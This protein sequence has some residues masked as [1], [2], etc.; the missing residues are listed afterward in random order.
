M[1]SSHEEFG[2]APSEPVEPVQPR[3]STTGHNTEAVEVGKPGRQRSL[4]GRRRSGQR[5]RARPE[6]VDQSSSFPLATH[7]RADPVRLQLTQRDDT[8]IVGGQCRNG[9]KS[10][11]HRRSV[12]HGCDTIRR[13]RRGRRIRPRRTESAPTTSSAARR[14]GETRARA[15]NTSQEDQ[16]GAYNRWRG[17]VASRRGRVGWRG[18]CGRRRA[19]RWCSCRRGRRRRCR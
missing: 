1:G 8:V 11:V 13:S 14:P 6:P 19:S 4:E 18:S 3:A 16:I 17:E 7:R 10:I 9:A 5:K 2:R 12:P 15:P